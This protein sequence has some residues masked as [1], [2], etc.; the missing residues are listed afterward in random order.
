MTPDSLT[1]DPVHITT[2]LLDVHIVVLE[3]NNDK[4]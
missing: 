4:G 3:V 2:T 1:P